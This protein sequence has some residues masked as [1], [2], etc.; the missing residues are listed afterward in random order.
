MKRRIIS[1]LLAAVILLGTVVITTPGVAAA[2]KKTTSTAAIA[3]IKAFEGFSAK[4]Y[5]D[6]NQWTVGYG[7][8]CPDEKYEEYFTKGISAEAAE[9]LL[10]EALKSFETRLNKFIDDNGLSLSQHQFDALISFTYNVGTAWMNDSS[11]TIYK[12][13]KNKYTGSDMIF[14]LTQWCTITKDG[15]KVMQTGLVNRRLIEANLY[16][17]GVYSKQPPERRVRRLTEFVLL[18]AGYRS[19]RRC[20]H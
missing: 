1:F 13:V 9:A 17:N 14:A 7:T 15:E 5:K 16:L 12:A 11:A 3:L 6:G 8:E 18:T 20:L 4:P 19:C 10:Q 2:S